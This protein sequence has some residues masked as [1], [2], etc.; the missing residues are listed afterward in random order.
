MSIR[1]W[2]RHSATPVTE[3]KPFGTSMHG[4]RRLQRHPPKG[5]HRERHVKRM[6]RLFVVRQQAILLGFTS[7]VCAEFMDLLPGWQASKQV[8]L[9][10]ISQ[11]VVPGTSA[12][13][14]CSLSSNKG[15]PT[16]PQLPKSKGVLPG[17]RRISS[18]WSVTV[19]NRRGWLIEPQVAQITVEGAG[20][21][22]LNADVATLT[23]TPS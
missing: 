14:F 20:R 15:I 11:R 21:L 2:L 19:R 7:H 3:Q 17:G 10:V 13:L 16:R 1:F 9:L 5:K 8:S 23:R 18:T 6:Q 4:P 22:P 12:R